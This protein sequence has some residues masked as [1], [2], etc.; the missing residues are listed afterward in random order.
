MTPRRT[1]TRALAVATALTLAAPGS[2][3]AAEGLEGLSEVLRTLPAEV[4]LLAYERLTLE[5]DDGRVYQAFARVKGTAPEL[6]TDPDLHALAKLAFLSRS[7]SYGAISRRDVKEAQRELKR[8]GRGMMLADVQLRAAFLYLARAQDVAHKLVRDTRELVRNEG[9][10]RTIRLAQECL[11]GLRALNRTMAGWADAGKAI[12][13]GGVD[14]VLERARADAD[15]HR[16]I[17]MSRATCPADDAPYALDLRAAPP[18]IRC[19]NHEPPK[20]VVP[21]A[22]PPGVTQLAHTNAVA[23]ARI[24]ALRPAPAAPMPPA[25]P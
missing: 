18:E 21:M 10:R 25:G 11:L 17:G 6:L 4:T 9:I 16:D 8:Q 12:P 13:A 20:R 19:P 5:N 1:W 2:R 15:A 22:P 14:E 7:R 24:Q 3:L 23:W